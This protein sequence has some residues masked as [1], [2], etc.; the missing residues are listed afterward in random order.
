MHYA[1]AI[2]MLLQCLK[3]ENNRLEHE[4]GD[5]VNDLKHQKDQNIILCDEVSRLEMNLK[6]NKVHKMPK[7]FLFSIS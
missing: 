4:L 6:R 1:Y 3:E 2:L 7:R 5:A